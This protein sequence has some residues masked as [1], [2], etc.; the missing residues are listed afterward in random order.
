MFSTR[1]PA[2]LTPNRLT[3]AVMERRRAGR[4]FIDLTES[5]PTCAGID[6]PPGLLAA[7]ADPRAL[8]YAP[9]PL[10]LLDARR[11]VAADYARRGME[12]DP[13]RVAL[14]AGTSE[15]YSILFKLLTEPGDEVLVPRPSYPLFELLTSLDG[16]I[17]RT[18]DLEYRRWL[19]GR[20]CQ[21]RTASGPSDASVARRQSQQPHR[22]VSVCR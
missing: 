22:L 2:N 15:S 10:G 8:V 1:V 11:A 3:Q 19:G 14:T 9:A 20:F 16:V 5:N 6:Y 13:G 18:Y 12:V 4:P 7:L 17:V 21:H